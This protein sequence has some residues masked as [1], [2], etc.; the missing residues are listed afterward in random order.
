MDP[1]FA[2][3]VMFSCFFWGFLAADPRLNKFGDVKGCV[4]LG[5]G[6]L[7]T[8]MLTFDIGENQILRVKI[9]NGHFFVGGIPSGVWPVAVEGEGVPVEYCSSNTTPLRAHVRSAATWQD[10][11]IKPSSHAHCLPG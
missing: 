1:W 7:A 6:P 3:R 10:L 2:I 9:R 5:R 4:W 8:G 11:D